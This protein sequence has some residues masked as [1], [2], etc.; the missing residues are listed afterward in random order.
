MFC[1]G[2]FRGVVGKGRGG[3]VGRRGVAALNELYT[4][5]KI[6]LDI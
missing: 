1:E 6:I 5:L 2:G 4:N 3:E